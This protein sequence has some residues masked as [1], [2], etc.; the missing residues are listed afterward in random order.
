MFAQLAE[1]SCSLLKLVIVFSKSQTRTEGG[2]SF[3]SASFLKER[4]YTSQRVVGKAGDPSGFQSCPG[5]WHVRTASSDQVALA[6]AG[7]GLDYVNSVMLNAREASSQQGK[8]FMG[9]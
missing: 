6:G 2:T 3:V 8:A 7:G 9:N 1:E 5:S 4:D